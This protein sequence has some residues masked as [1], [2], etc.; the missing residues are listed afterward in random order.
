VFFLC[1]RTTGELFSG[2]LSSQGKWVKTL[3]QALL[4]TTV[5]ERSS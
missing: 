2:W 4:S 1:L 5:N 3:S